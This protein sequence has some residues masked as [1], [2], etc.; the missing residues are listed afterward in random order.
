LTTGFK[1][2]NILVLNGLSILSSDPQ[3]LIICFSGIL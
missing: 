3:G 1:L 2:S